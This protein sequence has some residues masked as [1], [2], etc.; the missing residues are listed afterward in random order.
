MY[1]SYRAAFKSSRTSSNATTTSS[2]SYC[3]GLHYVPV[4][5]K[6][7]T[8]E[9]LTIPTELFEEILE[10]N[11]PGR[12]QACIGTVQ[13]G[14]RLALM[15]LSVDAW[16]GVQ[17]CKQISSTAPHVQ[18][19]GG[20]IRLAALERKCVTGVKKI[21]AIGALSARTIGDGEFETAPSASRRVQDILSSTSFRQLLT[22]MA[23]AGAI[24]GP[25]LDNY[26]S[27]FGVLTYKNPIKLSIGGSVLVTT[28]WW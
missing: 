13:I 3:V 16:K 28:D 9:E 15:I 22:P 1:R 7:T 14:L 11:M 26:H 10:E 5:L 25:N 27:A 6:S 24:L 18:P 12:P 4:T 8:S 19:Y 20:K 23:A 21:P 17:Q 2:H